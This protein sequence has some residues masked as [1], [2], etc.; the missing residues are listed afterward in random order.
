VK[1]SSTA[2]TSAASISAR[3]NEA[4][5]TTTLTARQ[6]WLEKYQSLTSSGSKITEDNVLN[7]DSVFTCVRVLAESMASM[8]LDLLVTSTKGKTKRIEKDDSNLLH[9]LMR[10]QPNSETTAYEFRFWLMC[11]ALIRGRGVAQIQRDGSGKIIALWQLNASRL[12]PKRAPDG[13]LVYTYT[14]ASEQVKKEILL[15]ADEVFQIQMMPYGGLIGYCLTISQREA[16]GA[17]KAA[18]EYSAEFFANGGA[19]TGVIEV[20][21]TLEEAAYQRLKKDWKE[22]HTKKGKRHGIPILE[23][24]AKFHA[25][26]LDHE[27]SQLLE[28]RKFARST[29]AGLFRIPSHLI[30]D[31]DKATFNNIEHQDLGFAKHTLRPWMTNWEQ[32]ANMSLL[33]AAER[34]TKQFKFNDRDLLRGD[35]KSRADAY[36]VLIQSGV[37]SPNDALEAENMNPYE[38]GDTHYV[39]GALRPT[40]QPYQSASGRPASN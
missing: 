18:E 34:R 17:S 14:Y 6:N 27:E 8:P 24:D 29:I 1:Q 35:F 23:G 39:Q 9:D 3:Y 19:V 4:L 30:N 26:S 25:L 37:M 11:D 20:P 5:K 36:S 7:I 31:L 38:G 16:L 2:K 13:R 15:E 40:D 22:N 32:R 10:N 21:E 28:T 12:R 33:T